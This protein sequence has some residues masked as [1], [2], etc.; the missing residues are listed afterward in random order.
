MTGIVWFAEIDGTIKR[1]ASHTHSD[2]FKLIAPSVF[3]NIRQHQHDPGATQMQFFV[4][5][6]VVDDVEELM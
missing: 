2:Q 4:K 1:G 5:L 3:L 6:V